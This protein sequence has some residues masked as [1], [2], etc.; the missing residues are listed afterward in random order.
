MDYGLA[1]ITQDPALEKIVRRSSDH[2]GY[3]LRLYENCTAFAEDSGNNERGV[4]VVDASTCSQPRFMDL[5][6]VLNEAPAWQVIYL[7]STSVRQMLQS[8]LGI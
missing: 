2:F 4:V 6:M 8:A 1:L 3:E 5:Q 7:P